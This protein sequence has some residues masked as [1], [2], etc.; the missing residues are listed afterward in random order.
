M[1]FPPLYKIIGHNYTKNTTKFQRDRT[2]IYEKL[3]GLAG[4][5]RDGG[6]RKDQLVRILLNRQGNKALISGVRTGKPS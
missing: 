1:G 2:K 5:C 6:E 4:L 3:S